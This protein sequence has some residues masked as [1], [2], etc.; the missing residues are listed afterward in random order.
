MTTI[1]LDIKIK[2]VDNK[3]ADLGGLMYCSWHKNSFDKKFDKKI[4]F[5]SSLVKKTDYDAKILEIEVKYFT[6]SDYNKFTSDILDAKVKQKELVNKSNIS[7]LVKNPDLNAKLATLA[8]KAELKAEQDKI[9]KLETID[10]NYFHRK[11]FW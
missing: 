7:N 5:V 2:E 6:T 10:S 4:T 3:I 11:C 8:T 9:V 1:V